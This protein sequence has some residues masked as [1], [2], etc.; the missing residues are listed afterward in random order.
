MRYSV[1]SIG[2]AAHNIVL[3]PPRNKKQAIISDVQAAGITPKP[4]NH[5]VQARI[6]VLHNRRLHSLNMPLRH[7]RDCNCRKSAYT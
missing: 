1:A 4:I 3:L 7:I 5:R 6:P 2:N